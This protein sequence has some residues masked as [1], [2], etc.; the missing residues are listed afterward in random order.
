V[1][2]IQPGGRMTAVRVRAK[3][4]IC[5]PVFPLADQREQ[6]I[7]VQPFVPGWEARQ[8]V[9]RQAQQSAR[10]LTPVF[11]EMH[12][13][14]GQLNEAL[15]KVPNRSFP[16]RQPQGLQ[17]LMR[18]KE[19]LTVERFEKTQVT[20]IESYRGARGWGMDREISRAH[21]AR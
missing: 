6:I 11:L 7:E 18:L 16:E 15:V 21:R 12:K 14:P 3:R 2:R 4:I 10:R 20:Q 5:E 1:G 8:V 17:N 19:L 13:S 9:P